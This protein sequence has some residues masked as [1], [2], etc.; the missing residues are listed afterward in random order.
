MAN[1]PPV[2]KKGK[3][4]YPGNYRLVNFTLVHAK[5]IN[6]VHLE[7]SCGHVKVLLFIGNSHHGFTKG[8]S[9]LTNPITL[10]DEMTGSVNK[11]E[12]SGYDLL[13]F[14]QD[15]WRGLPTATTLYSSWDTVI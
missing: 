2:F 6:Q 7:V 9:C 1:A 8:K 10:C 5:I 11:A 3:K 14:Q 13:G 4:H 15:F 12:S